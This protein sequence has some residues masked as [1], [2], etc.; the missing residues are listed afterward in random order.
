MATMKDGN[1]FVYLAN[2]EKQNRFPVMAQ[3]QKKILSVMNWNDENNN[4]Q[5][6]EIL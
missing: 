6:Q 1:G 3:T 4:Q 5:I 2:G